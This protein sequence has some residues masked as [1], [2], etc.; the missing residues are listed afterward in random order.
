MGGKRQSGEAHVNRE[1]E[2]ADARLE[3][4]DCPPHV[5]GG[6]GG[7]VLVQRQLVDIIG[8]PRPSLLPSRSLASTMPEAAPWREFLKDKVRNGEGRL[9]ALDVILGDGAPTDETDGA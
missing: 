5:P 6:A 3:G 9:R 8:G 2:F 7:A 4:L 1:F